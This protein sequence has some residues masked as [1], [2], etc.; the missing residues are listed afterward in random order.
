MRLNA[1]TGEVIMVKIMWFSRSRM[2]RSKCVAAQPLLASVLCGIL[3]MKCAHTVNG[4]EQSA[5]SSQGATVPKTGRTPLEFP[6]VP[7][8]QDIL[9]ARVFEEPLVPIGSEPSAAENTGLAAALN[10]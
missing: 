6:A 5:P 2:A 8:A 3:A 9:R 4:A 1:D 7:T 10:G